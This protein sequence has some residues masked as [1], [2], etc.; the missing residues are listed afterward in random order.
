MPS[1]LAYSV[2]GL[3][4]AL[5]LMLS[6][7]SY[8]QTQYLSNDEFIS[9]SFNGHQPK[10]KVLWLDADT[11]QAVETILAH[12][13]NKMRLRYWQQANETVWI[14]DEIGKESMITVGIHVNNQA[15]ERTKVL[16]YRESRGDEVRHDFF[17]DQFKS[18]KLTDN[19]QLD[20][21]IDGITGAT[22]SVKALTK[23]ARIALLLDA[24]VT[25][26]N[27]DIQ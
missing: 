25:A 23:L 12:S 15:I 6:T 1:H 4:F 21:H 11:K 5:A 8:G 18:A 7:P 24:K 2:I 26:Q 27:S 14:M 19:H 22:L 16:V 9:Q 3:F 20:Q 10:A 17:T 13:F